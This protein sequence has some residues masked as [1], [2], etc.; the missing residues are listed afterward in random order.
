MKRN[1]V[2]IT[3]QRRCSRRH[4]NNRFALL[5]I[6]GPTFASQAATDQLGLKNVDRPTWLEVRSDGK[7]IVLKSDLAG[8]VAIRDREHSKRSHR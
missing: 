3:E 4:P 1:P 6:V 7:R 5:I 2:V 8:E